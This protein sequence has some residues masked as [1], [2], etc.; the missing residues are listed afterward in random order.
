MSCANS[1]LKIYTPRKCSAPVVLASFEKKKKKKRTGF[2]F[3]YN[4]PFLWQMS[5]NSLAISKYISV[6][7]ED[8]LF[9][10]AKNHT[11]IHQWK[12][13]IVNCFDGFSLDASPS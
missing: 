12:T 6:L 3:E 8:N 5:I 2:P 7:G 1:Y 11:D 4:F 10:F 9:V 13:C